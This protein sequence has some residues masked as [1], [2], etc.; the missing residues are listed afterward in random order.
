M[1]P[2]DQLQTALVQRT[3]LTKFLSGGRMKSY[4]AALSPA[5]TGSRVSSFEQ[6]LGACLPRADEYSRP[7][8]HCVR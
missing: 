3:D 1:K 2:K 5:T 6:L 8:A 4:Y 7:F